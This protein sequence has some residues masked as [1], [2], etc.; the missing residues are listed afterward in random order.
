MDTGHVDV[1]SCCRRNSLSRNLNKQNDFV[2]G[3]ISVVST[4][5]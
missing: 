3:Y 1:Q 2:V 4:S 5:L